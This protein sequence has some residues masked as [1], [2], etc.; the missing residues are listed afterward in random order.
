M[1]Q[2]IKQTAFLQM[3]EGGSSNKLK[4]SM[5]RAKFAM[6]KQQNTKGTRKLKAS[7]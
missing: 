4:G 3:L 6:P 5:L 2:K 7:V 1:A